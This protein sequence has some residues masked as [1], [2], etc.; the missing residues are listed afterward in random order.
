MGAATSSY[1]IEGAFR[2]DGKGSPSGY[3][4]HEKGQDLERTT[5]NIACDHYKLYASDIELMK[6]IGLQGYRFSIN[7]PRVIPSGI[8]EHNAKGFDFYK[9][10]ADLLNNAG[11]ERG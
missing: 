3:L 6:A 10:L 11:I 8:G 9:K 4:L 7:W 1:Q 5:G 2:E